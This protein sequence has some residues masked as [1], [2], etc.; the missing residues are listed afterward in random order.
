MSTTIKISRGSKSSRCKGVNPI[1]EIRRVEATSPRAAS[2]PVQYTVFW[3]VVLLV[4]DLLLFVVA[5]YTASALVDHQW[6]FRSALSSLLHSS[7]VFIAVWVGI[8]YVLGL[9]QRSLALSFK[10]EFYFAV[11]A[12]VLGIG[13]QL[14]IFTAF[15]SWSTSRMI[16]IL[17]A[18]VAI[19]LVGT[20][21]AAIHLVRSA[22]QKRG[23]KRILVVGSHSQAMRVC[24]GLPHAGSDNVVTLTY[25]TDSAVENANEDVNEPEAWFAAATQWKCERVILASLKDQEKVRRLLL[26]CE[27]SGIK[28]NLA[29]PSMDIGTYDLEVEREGKQHLLVPIRPK[30]ARPIPRRIKRLLD[31]TLSSLA[32]LIVSPVMAIAALAVWV[33]SGAPILF[34]QE[35]IG[36]FGD[37]FNIFKFRTMKASSDSSWAKPG[38]SRITRVGA[39]LR[40]TSIDE[41]PQLFNVLR[42]DMSLVGPRPEMRAFEEMFASRVPLYAE[43]RLALPGITGLAQVNMRRNLSP[44][45][46]EQVLSYDLFYLEHWSV[47]LDLTVL[48]KTATEFL[49]HRAV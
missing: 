4:S 34:R 41:L 14:V 18:A 8:F 15:P 36:R 17:S 30:I 40:R 25:D 3:S 38:D 13:P 35:R 28:V 5:S 46:V 22:E 16:L 19:V 10:D 45:D 49:F 20:S 7:F 2:G 48:L 21:R 1:S 6:G 37:V 43:R 33:D 29:L 9:Y 12:L 39:F 47:F 26:L 31:A 24:G 11:I 23:Q 27:D 44:D 42:G 32:I